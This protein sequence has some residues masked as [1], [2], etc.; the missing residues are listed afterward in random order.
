M[1]F[2]FTKLSQKKK[3]SKMEDHKRKRKPDS[4]IE[5]E[6]KGYFDLDTS[7]LINLVSKSLRKKFPKLDKIVL[8]K[9][10][11]KTFKLAQTNLI[12]EYCP[13]VPKDQGVK[14]KLHHQIHFQYE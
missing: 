3:K 12:E 9:T 6:T 10:L 8:D 7:P 11:T 2:F 5:E 1:C 13:A 4:N 14:L